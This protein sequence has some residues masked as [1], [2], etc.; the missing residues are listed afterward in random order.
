MLYASCIILSYKVWLLPASWSSLD[1]YLGKSL[2]STLVALLHSEVPPSSL[3]AEDRARLASLPLEHLPPALKLG[4]SLAVLSQVRS[5]V[6]QFLKLL[7]VRN[8]FVSIFSSVCL[9]Q[10]Q[11]MS[12]QPL[13]PP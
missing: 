8:G 6:Y 5:G 10:L 4:A 2:S 9:A 12:T 1:S 11:A 13:A 3:E 7:A